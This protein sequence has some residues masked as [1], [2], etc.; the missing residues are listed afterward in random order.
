MKKNSG[1]Q[2]I[3]V[4]GEDHGGCRILGSPLGYHEVPLVYLARVLHDMIDVLEIDFVSR[5]MGDRFGLKDLV[6]LAGA[7]C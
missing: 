7:C 4:H 1:E 6:G 2:P 3:V 5:C